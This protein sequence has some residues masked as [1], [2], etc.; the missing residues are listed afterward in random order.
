MKKRHGG[1]KAQRQEG[2]GKRPHHFAP[3]C[4]CAFVPFLLCI[5]SASAQT[6]SIVGSLHNLSASG[7]G[8]IRAATE[9]E[10]CIF[11]H[12]PHNAAPIQ[13]LWNR[14]VPVNAYTVY[15][16]NSLDAKPGQPTGT[17]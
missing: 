3:L 8:Y 13:P 7:R 1:T 4:L 6:T 10:I 17:S 15:S 9:Q 11:C 14:N 2:P 16:S 12:T 5:A